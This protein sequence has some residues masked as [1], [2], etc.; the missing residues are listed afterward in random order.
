[1]R[2]T[3]V[4]ANLSFL[5]AKSV[6]FLFLTEVHTC[7]EHSNTQRQLKWGYF[8]IFWSWRKIFSLPNSDLLILTTPSPS[9]TPNT[10]QMHFTIVCSSAGEC[11]SLCD[12]SD[13][14]WRWVT[15][16]IYRSVLFCDLYS[17][18]R[19]TDFTEGSICLFS[20]YPSCQHTFLQIFL[21]PST[22]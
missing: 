9:L 20:S 3:Y 13:I 19:N 10:V 22:N 14:C 16:S 6:M 11:V 5:R 1:M 15:F 12:G 2:H 18:Q 4:R 8:V 7:S 17:F 21:H